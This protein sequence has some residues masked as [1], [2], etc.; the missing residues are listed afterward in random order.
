MQRINARGFAVVIRG[1]I[2]VR[3][4]S[5]Y[6]RGAV[7]NWL[8]VSAGQTISNSMSDDQIF[9]IWDVHRFEASAAVRP[10]RIEVT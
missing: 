1:Q 3:T 4:V 2:D 5:P 9:A 6:I 7:I 8:V 10:V